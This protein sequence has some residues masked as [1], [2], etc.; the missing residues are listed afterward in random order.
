MIFP[1]KGSETETR[2]GGGGLMKPNRKLAKIADR[3]FGDFFFCLEK[4]DVVGSRV[5]S[6]SLNRL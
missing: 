5:V 2:V 1:F 6:T 4:Q 3:H